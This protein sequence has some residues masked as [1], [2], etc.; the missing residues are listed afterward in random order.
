MLV[1]LLMCL[2][3][4]GSF[5][6]GSFNFV[7]GATADPTNDE[8][9]KCANPMEVVK[10]FQE[11]VD[12]KEF[13]KAGLLI[14]DDADISTPFGMKTKDQFIHDLQGSGP[15]WGEIVAGNNERQCVTEGVR[16]MGFIKVK[17]KR[18]VDVNEEGKMQKIVI[19][20]K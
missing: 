14:A 1:F 18:I 7:T 12:Q 8:T 16:K 9:T 20:K 13:D 6:T 4:W 11:L 3:L 2:D 19:T 17:L 10:S 15:V 5:T